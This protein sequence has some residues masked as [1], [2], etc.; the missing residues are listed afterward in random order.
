MEYFMG[1]AKGREVKQVVE[2]NRELYTSPIIL[3]E[4]Y[5]KSIR[6]DGEAR[7]KQRIEFILNRTGVIEVDERIGIEAGLIHVEGREKAKDFGLADALI[8]ASTRSKKIKVL[9]LDHHFKFFLDSELL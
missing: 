1:T 4:I 2:G 3:A 8:L 7:A 9:T 5:S 6:V